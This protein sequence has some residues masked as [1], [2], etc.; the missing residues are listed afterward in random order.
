VHAIGACVVVHLLLNN[1]GLLDSL[2]KEQEAA[3]SNCGAAIEAQQESR[4][5]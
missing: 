1:E 4:I 2:H 5:C 3:Y